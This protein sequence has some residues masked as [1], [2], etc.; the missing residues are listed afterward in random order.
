MNI[1]EEYTPVYDHPL[2]VLVI[3]KELQIYNKTKNKKD[4]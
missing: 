1:P 2:K 4:G 3:L